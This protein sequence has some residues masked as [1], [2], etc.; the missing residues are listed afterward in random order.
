[1]Y[2]E[3]QGK[4]MLK[5]YFGDEKLTAPE[6]D[7]AKFFREDPNASPAQLA[8]EAANPEY[9]G[10]PDDRPWSERHKAVLW[11]AMLAAVAVLGWLALRGLRSAES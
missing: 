9:A 11:A 7:Y 5:L 1:M 3:P 10:R 8:P 2:F 4:G 6:Y